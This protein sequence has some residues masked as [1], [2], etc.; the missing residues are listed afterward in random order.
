MHATKELFEEFIRERRYLRNLSE[1]T[2]KHYRE[3]YR[4]FEKEGAWENLYKQ[5][6]LAAIVK[7]RER[8]VKAG[9]C[10]RLYPGCLSLPHLAC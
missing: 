6:L 3:S 7:I 8:G 10:Q 9:G 4:A 1:K 2:L 5:S